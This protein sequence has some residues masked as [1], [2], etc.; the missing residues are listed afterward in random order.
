MVLHDYVLHVQEG[1]L[2]K[3]FPLLPKSEPMAHWISVL[4]RDGMLLYPIKME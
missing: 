3:Q 1:P 4:W 2:Q